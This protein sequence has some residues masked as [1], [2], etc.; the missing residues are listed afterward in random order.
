MKHGLRINPTYAAHLRQHGLDTLEGVMAYD[1]GEVTRE[2]P[3]RITVRLAFGGDQKLYLKRH[4]PP[5]SQ[6]A[7]DGFKEWDNIES[8][9][10]RGISCPRT[11]A[12][13]GGIVNGAP[14]GFLITAAVPDAIPMDDYLANLYR[15]S[16]NSL[17]CACK[18]RLIRKLADLARRFHDL[19][20]HHKDFYLCHVFVNQH[21]PLDSPLVLIDLQRLGRAHWFRRRWIVKDLAAL[22]Y[23]A[24]D[25]FTTNTDRLRFL[26]TYLGVVRL[27][28]WARRLL[29]AVMRKTDRIR[30][31]DAKLQSAAR[32]RKA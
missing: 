9:S 26:L 24:R 31:H 23:S 5:N 28:S 6:A 27:D 14:C 18:R 17:P 21:T 7:S 19:G 32:S 4:F 2:V 20:Y 3:G 8:L 29:R 13:G 15:V 10:S 22:N 30:R 1:Q 11:V 25:E 16:G 12:A